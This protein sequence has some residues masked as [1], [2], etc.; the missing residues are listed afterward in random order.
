MTYDEWRVAAVK[1]VYTRTIEKLVDDYRKDRPTI[2]LLP[3]GMGSRLLRS[4]ER[5]EGRSEIPTPR[6]PIWIDLGIVLGEALKL[7]IDDQGR[8]LGKHAIVA[9]GPLAI[10]G[11]NS[12]DGVKNFCDDKRWNFVTFGYDWR[13]PVRE[14]ADNLGRF[15]AD[16]KDAVQERHGENPLPQ[17]HL[18]A[19]SQGGLV[20][21]LFLN[22][23]TDG[24]T[25]FDKA[26]GVATPFYG[27][28]TQQQRYYVGNEILINCVGYDG[29]KVV[30]IVGS[31]PGPYSL[32]FLPKA[33]FD[34]YGAAIGLD[35]YP[36]TEPGGGRALDPYDPANLDRYLPSVQRQFLDEARRV[37]N[38]IAAPLPQGIETQFFNIGASGKKSTP[39]SLSWKPLPEGYKVGDASPV[40]AAREG[41]GDGT[42]P[43]WSAFHTGTPVE[44]REELKDVDVHGGLAEHAKSLTILEKYVEGAKPGS[45]VVAE[46]VDAAPNERYSGPEDS[47]TPEEVEAHMKQSLQRQIGADDLSANDVINVYRCI[48]LFF[49]K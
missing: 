16:F 13:R 41:A 31:L 8:D 3:G 35:H 27:T 22:G 44:N 49:T 20:L 18:Y 15:L 9:D 24:E 12:Y 25:W 14:A 45:R 29:P 40:Q 42:V 5:Y 26:F 30:K 39:I 32:M 7:E 48:K 23:I 38:E 4:D 37:Y 33:V 11:F 46:A 28:S 43:S 36:V 10:P 17:T 6:N 19:H 34:R 47:A 1:G 21:K 2:V